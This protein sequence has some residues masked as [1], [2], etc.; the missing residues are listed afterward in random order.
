MQ[1]R[2]DQNRDVYFPFPERNRRKRPFGHRW[3]CREVRESFAL[4]CPSFLTFRSDVWNANQRGRAVGIYSLAP[5]LGPAVGPIAGA[6]VAETTSWR[7]VF[8]ST[9]IAAALIQLSGIFFLKE[10]Y[11]PTILKRKA[12]RLRK[13]TGNTS[14]HTEF[15]SDKNLANVLSTNLVRAFRLLATQ[16]IIQVISLY[17]AYIFGLFYLILSTYPG[18]WQGVYGESIGIGGLNYISLGIGSFIGAQGNALVNDRIYRRLKA[19]NNDVGRPEFRVPP[20]FI[21]SVLIPIGLFWYGWSVQAHTHWIVPNIGIVFVAAGYMLCLICMQTYVIDSYTRY[22]ASGLAAVVLLRS[23]AGFG[24]PLFAPYMYNTLGYGWGNS[25]LG[26]AAIVVGIPAPFL[27]WIYG[28]KLR[29]KSTYAAG[30]G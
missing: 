11:A 25:V 19:R 28:E 12:D 1:L 24:F 9:T 14:L 20:M 2:P 26:F 18:V 21:G 5:L 29:S 8:W 23:I 27:F 13:E 16:P 22:A 17:M 15:E 3:R 7:W 30:G 4:N 10:T 6:F